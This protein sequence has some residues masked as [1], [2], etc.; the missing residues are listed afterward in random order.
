MLFDKLN[1]SKENQ[2]L[3]NIIKKPK[4]RKLEPI[5]TDQSNKNLQFRGSNKNLALEKI[6]TRDSIINQNINE[7]DDEGNESDRFRAR[8]AENASG[9]NGNG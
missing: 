8:G 9:G 6:K 4:P 1:N 5:I 3:I 2:K 7:E